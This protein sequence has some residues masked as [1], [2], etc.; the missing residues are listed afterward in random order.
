MCKIL[1][2]KSNNTDGQRS[3]SKRDMKIVHEQAA[4]LKM[5]LL[6]LEDKIEAEFGSF[7]QK[8]PNGKALEL[9]E[10]YDV[11]E[12]AG[13]GTATFMDLQA[14]VETMTALISERPGTK[15]MKLNKLLDLMAIFMDVPNNDEASSTV[16]LER[17]KLFIKKEVPKNIRSTE[18][19]FAQQKSTNANA[20]QIC[21]WCFDASL[22]VQEW[23]YFKTP[24]INRL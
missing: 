19:Q 15:G 16:Y 20:V 1:F 17:F 21:V 23:Y 24:D 14:I 6:A 7:I 10:L 11:L 3:G 2:E 18:E 9:K 8:D 5:G 12:A 13:F 22:S 4:V